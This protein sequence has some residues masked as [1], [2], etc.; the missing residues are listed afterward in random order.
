MSQKTLR[1]YAE[2]FVTLYSSLP[3]EELY[4]DNVWT[5]INKLSGQK[6]YNM[7]EELQW[8]KME[9]AEETDYDIQKIYIINLLIQKMFESYKRN[10]DLHQKEMNS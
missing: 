5:D 8:Y 6:L 4:N 3:P 1:E 10:V 9:L 2:Q 7:I